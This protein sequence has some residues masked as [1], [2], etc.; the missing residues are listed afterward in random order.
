MRDRP[1]LALLFALAAGLADVGLAQTYPSKPVRLVVPLPPGGIADISSRLLAEHMARGLGQP[2]LVENRPGGSSI[3]GT[4][5]VL[6]S[7]ADG[8]TLLVVFPSFIVNPAL[9]RGM[10]FDPLRDF[11]AVGQTMSVPMAIA[12]GPSVPARSLPELVALARAKPGEIS[13]G[14]PGNG[15]TLHIMGE[16]LKL[17]ANINLVHVPFQGLSPALAAATGGHIHMVYGHP[18]EIAPSV[19]DGR[20]RALVV[21]SGNRADVLP[22]TPTMR[23]VGYPELEAT[24]WSGIVVASGTPP[25]VVLRLNVELVAA[26]RN[27]DLQARFRSNGMSPV[28]STPEQFGAFLQAESVRY[29]KVVREAGIKADQ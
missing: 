20:V 1:L 26:L 16:L 18:T 3:V 17:T 4:E 10:S 7:P 22:D 21:T 6:R 2:V 13:Y 14:T 28:A 19:K 15:T 27:A 11:K 24:N 23:E 5:A 25:P 12:V 8:H 9:R 29:A